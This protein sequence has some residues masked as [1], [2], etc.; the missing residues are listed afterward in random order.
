MKNNWSALAVV[1]LFATA[2]KKNSNTLE[3]LSEQLESLSSLVDKSSYLKFGY[4]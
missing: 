3:L 1:S 2:C 4:I